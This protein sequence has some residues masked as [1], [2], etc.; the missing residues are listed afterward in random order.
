MELD[1]DCLTRFPVSALNPSGF[2]LVEVRQMVRSSAALRAPYYLHLC[3]GS[4]GRASHPT[5][6]ALLGKSMAYL[7]TDFIKTHGHGPD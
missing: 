7:I 5:E 4:P 6:V 2:S 1:L 3:E